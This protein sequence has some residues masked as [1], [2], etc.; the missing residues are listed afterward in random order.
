MSRSIENATAMKTPNQLSFV[1]SDAWQ[2]PLLVI[3]VVVTCFSMTVV[4]HSST[5]GHPEFWHA[6]AVTIV[7]CAFI[8]LFAKAR[9]GCSAIPRSR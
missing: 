5:P 3:L 1:G 7:L 6:V 9:S 8:P 4:L 2:T